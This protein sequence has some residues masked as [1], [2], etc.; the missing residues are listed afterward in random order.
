M[1]G[2]ETAKFRG[3]P[4]QQGLASYALRMK[5]YQPHPDSINCASSCEASVRSSGADF[6]STATPLWRNSTSCSRSSLIGATNTCTISTFSAKIMAATRPIPATS[7]CSSFGF[8]Q[9][10]RFRYVYNYYAQWQCD[11]RLE[12]TLPFDT[13]RF[14]PVCTGGKWPAPPEHVQDAWT[15][16]EL[17]DEHRYPSW[18]HYGCW[19]MPR[20][21]LL[22]AP[23]DV[24]IREALG[25]LDEMREAM[26]RLEPINSCSPVRFNGA[27]NAQLRTQ[28]W[29]GEQES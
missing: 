20:R 5:H 1:P 10:E 17:L 12:S 21:S 8:Q 3:D 24:S 13:T 22:D 23:A 29:T 15:Y 18:T 19:P 25:D 14:Y 16:L 11:I 2:G 7:R 28:T 4:L 27:L 9:G 26:D 6:W